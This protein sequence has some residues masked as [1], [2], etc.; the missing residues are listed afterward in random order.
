MEKLVYVM[1]N[2]TKE[3]DYNKVKGTDYTVTLEPVRENET[4]E[5]RNARLERIAKAQAGIKKAYGEYKA[6]MA[7]EDVKGVLYGIVVR[8]PKKATEE[9]AQA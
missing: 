7:Q 1:A 3:T 5:M 9:V 6:L 4:E 8:K 2:G